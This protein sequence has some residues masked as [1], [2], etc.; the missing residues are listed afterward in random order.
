MRSL[1]PVQPLTIHVHQTGLALAECYRLS[2]YD[3][4]IAAS[5]LHETLWSEDLQDGLVLD[6]RLRIV[7]PFLAP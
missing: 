3:A 7:N 1:L 4:M 2:I 6:G 5:V